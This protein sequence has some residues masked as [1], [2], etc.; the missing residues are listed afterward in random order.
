MLIL[1]RKA[2]ESIVIGDDIV[3]TIVEAGRDQVRVG[4]EA[5]RS[6]AVH[7]YEV[8]AEISKENAAAAGVAV[9]TAATAV[10]A[11]TL[12]RRPGG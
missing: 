12:P 2:G 9:P 11:K 4:I 1:T 5:P 3:I 10:S 6:V 8:Y 7:R